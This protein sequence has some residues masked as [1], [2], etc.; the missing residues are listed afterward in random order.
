MRYLWAKVCVFF[1]LHFDADQ[2]REAWANSHT[3]KIK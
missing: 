1:K 3:T 2:G